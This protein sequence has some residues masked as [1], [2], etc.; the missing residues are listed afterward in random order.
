MKLLGKIIRKIDKLIHVYQ[1]KY[2]VFFLRLKYP[3]IKLKNV[4]IEK[5][6]T[7]IK[8]NE[9]FLEIKN[10]FIKIGTTI[11]ASGSSKLSINGA[12]IGNYNMIVAHK[13]III[14]EGCEIA[15][16]CVIRDQDHDL[17]NIKKLV[18]SSIHIKKNVWIGNKVTITRGVDIGNNSVVGAN[19]VVTKSFDA[20]LLIAGVPAKKIKDLI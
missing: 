6:C 18:C 9:A 11:H 12:F 15:E 20:N 14:D 10:S 17:K 5:N 19:S 8:E 4:T 13:E 3:G 1:S 2:R 16:F 7:I